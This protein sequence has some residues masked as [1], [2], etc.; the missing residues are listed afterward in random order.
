MARMQKDLSLLLTYAN[1]NFCD[2]IILMLKE[3]MKTIIDTYKEKSLSSNIYISE[4]KN[5]DKIVNNSRIS[6]DKNNLKEIFIICEETDAYPYIV[7]CPIVSTSR[8]FYT[9]H[10]RARDKAEYPDILKFITSTE[11]KV[12]KDLIDCNPNISS[13]Y[14]IALFRLLQRERHYI[15]KKVK[16]TNNLEI[17]NLVISAIQDNLI[18]GLEL[19]AKYLNIDYIFRLEDD[20]FPTL[21]NKFPTWN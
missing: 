10:I 17:Y 18:F 20:S 13:S 5:C 21:K 2:I 11:F 16:E 1:A 15:L 19:A 14:E 6:V 8:T 12:K 3:E 9:I 4:M 7:K